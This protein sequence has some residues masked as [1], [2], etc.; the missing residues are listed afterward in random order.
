ME[1]P[2]QQ[3]HQRGRPDAS[4]AHHQDVLKVAGGHRQAL[5]LRGPRSGPGWGPLTYAVQHL[6]RGGAGHHLKAARNGQQWR[7]AGV[8]RRYADPV[9]LQG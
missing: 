7:P 2:E 1:G 8:R 9:Q 5:L 4:H 3:V 6:S